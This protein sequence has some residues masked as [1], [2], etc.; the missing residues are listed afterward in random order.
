MS[1]PARGGAREGAGR[2][3]MDGS[4]ALVERFSTR[5]TATQ[6]NTLDR[7]GGAAWLRQTLDEAAKA[8][9]KP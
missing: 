9:D 3:A 6:R 8:E 1:K 5:L 2:K 4:T 7:L